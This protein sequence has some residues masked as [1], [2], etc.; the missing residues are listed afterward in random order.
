M[1]HFKTLFFNLALILGAISVT[2]CGSDEPEPMPEPKPIDSEMTFVGTTTTHPVDDPAAEFTSSTPS[3]SV[4]LDK[5]TNTASILIGKA[6]FI[7]GMPALD[8]DFKGISIV[9]SD[10]TVTFDCKKLTPEIAGRPFPQFPITDLDA[11]LKVSSDEG[12]H[13]TSL[14][15][16][17]ICTYK[18]T[19]FLITFSGKRIAE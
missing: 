9:I 15:L 5:K 12:T 4:V 17:F 1:T 11:T 3:Y 6:Q 19:P 8:M 18:N 10:N 13:P 2:S 16:Q 14:T 7:Q